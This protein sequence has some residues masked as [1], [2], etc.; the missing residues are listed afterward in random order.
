M[1]KYLTSYA[2]SGLIFFFFLGDAYSANDIKFKIL[3]VNPSATK[4]TKT[5]ISQP[6]P[7]EINPDQDLLDK[8]GLEVKFDTQKKVFLL[9][10][11][12]E[13]GPKETR[14]FEVRM[15]DVWQVAPDQVEEIK[16]D[17]NTQVTALR[18]T[19]YHDVGKLL[20][21][22]A[23]EGLDRIIDEQSRPLGIKQHIEL[24]R[25]HREQLEEIK[26]NALSL[27]S[28]RQLED[29]KKGNIEEVR[30]IVEA[31]NPSSEPQEIAVRSFLPKEIRPDDVLDAQNFNILYDE[32]RKV[33]FLEKKEKFD[34][35]ESKKYVITVKNKWR[36]PESEILFYKDQTEKLIM[37]FRETSF[38]A[39]GDEQGK[40]ILEM[41]SEISQLQQ[42]VSSSMSLEEKMRAF[43]LNSQKFE[44][45]KAKI[46]NLQQIL[47][48]AAM[49]KNPDRDFAEKLRN[50][51]KKLAETQ[52]MVLMAIGMDPD[53]PITWWF[54]LGIILFL[55]I[56]SAV[57]YSVWIKKLKENK[58]GN[59]VMEATS[60]RPPPATPQPKQE[61]EGAKKK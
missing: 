3:A 11:E 47:P 39:Y 31:M 9:T 5:V 42:E 55:G 45:A 56:V 12:V 24:Y 35:N 19:K 52:K 33:Y 20:Y 58:W 61:D 26:T 7:P 60:A 6:L 29:E 28:M 22:K 8:A 49:E 21:Q 13:L 53:K 48:E 36:I 57:F 17:L 41:L 44:V 2:L 46:Q 32:S 18:G 30:F 15:R 16:K 23:V 54:I 34:G 37:L 43:V 27:E 14:T 38:E 40:M 51:I 4:N 50:L 25:A 59:K 10:Q 1:R